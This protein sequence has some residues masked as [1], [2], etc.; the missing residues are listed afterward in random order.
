MFIYLFFFFYRKAESYA[1]P[2]NTELTFTNLSEFIL[3]NLLLE[4]R[5]QAMVGLCTVWDSPEV[6]LNEFT[7]LFV[8]FILVFYYL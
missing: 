2:H 3:S 5:L 6:M 1:F 7:N 4:T 8:K